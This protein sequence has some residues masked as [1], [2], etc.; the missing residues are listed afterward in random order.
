MNKEELL[1]EARRRYRNCKIFKSALKIG[2]EGSKNIF[3]SVGAFEHSIE[4]HKN[5]IWNNVDNINIG[6]LYLDGKWAEI[7]EYNKSKKQY[8]IYY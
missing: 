7:V 5:I 8:E 4:K 6:W 1:A 2:V 3:G